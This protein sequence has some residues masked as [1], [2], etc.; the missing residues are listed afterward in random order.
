M[1][2]NP[3]RP[4]P[5]TF[6]VASALVALAGCTA[7]GPNYA[8]PRS[9][10]PAHWEAAIPHA[11]NSV[12]LAGWWGQFNDPV[13]SG[14]IDQAEKSS[15]SLA[16]ATA[17]IAESRA[18]LTGS[19]AKRAPAVTGSGRLART[20]A[21][22]D[23]PTAT[24]D[25]G[26]AAIDAS[27]EA[28]LFGRVLRGTEAAEARLEAKKFEWHA[29]RVSVAAEV[30]DAYV[31]YLACQQLVAVSARDVTSR[32]S[33][34]GLVGMLVEAGF[35]APVDGETTT[36]GLADAQSDLAG[37]RAQCDLTV[38][39]LVVLVGLPERDLRAR[40][41]RRAALGLPVPEAFTVG[42][43]PLN[44]LA[45]R[46]DLAAAERGLAAAT[47]DVGVAEANR[48]PR[49]TLSGSLSIGLVN[50]ASA[51]TSQPWSFGPSITLPLFDAGQRRAEVVAAEARLAQQRASF[52]GAVRQAAAEVERAM[53]ALDSSRTQETN[54]R[55]AAAGYA[56]VL[57]STE[58][59][60]KAGGTS[61]LALEEARRNANGTERKLLALQ[62]ER[63]RAWISLYK[64]VGGG[65]KASA[66]TDQ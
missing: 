21:N 52:E 40:L 26:V 44:V 11:G 43:V 56:R 61:L 35:R 46:P 31:G 63:V 13:L 3:Q 5:R 9:A 28:D 38:K 23:A 33:T 60:L 8:P 47:A 10:A 48:Y 4:T 17:R 30:A 36:A 18:A 16:A 49:L 25:T 1:A 15:P 12:E 59:N 6:V 66:G 58:S 65:W 62:R 42:T 45:Q 54:A 2:T 24:L 41:S 7:V 27:W 39:S 64:A 14:L 57:A 22:G 50:G 20:G 19:E 32:A 34:A 37:Q 53:V 55:A 51:V 29:A